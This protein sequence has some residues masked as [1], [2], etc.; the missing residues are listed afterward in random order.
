[1]GKAAKKTRK[2]GP[3]SSY[4]PAYAKQAF[5]A[6]SKGGFREVDLC[7]LF[8]IKSRHTLRAW[9]KKYPAFKAAVA[10]GRERLVGH[11]ADSMLKRACGYEYE[12]RTYLTDDAGVEKLSKRVVKHEPANVSAG[13]YL[14]C[15]LSRILELKD[16]WL[17]QSQM[18]LGAIGGGS[19]VVSVTKNYEKDPSGSDPVQS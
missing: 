12:E 1:M 7:D 11:V 10:D 15:N 13:I 14:T 6:I 16:R 9:M 5:L 18:E 8:G 19:L 3:K 4:K 17:Q 2:P